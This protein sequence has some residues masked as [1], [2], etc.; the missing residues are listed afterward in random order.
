MI[1][2]LKYGV[3]YSQVEELE[4]ALCI[5][6]LQCQNN[7]AVALPEQIFPNIPTLLG[8]DSIDRLEYTLSGGCT[9]HRVNGIAKKQRM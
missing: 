2:H 5:Q 4:T 3:S 8:W 6:K 1:N 7:E 9:P